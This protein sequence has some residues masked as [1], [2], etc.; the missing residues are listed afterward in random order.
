ME[1]VNSYLSELRQH[2]PSDQCED[3]VSELR[4]NLVEEMQELADSRGG[5]P[6]IKDERAVL[7]NLGHPLKVAAAYKTKRYLIGPNLYPAFLHTLRNTLLIGFLVVFLLRIAG[8]LEA[9][10][11]SLVDGLLFGFV[12]IGLW[13]AGVVGLIFV[14]L[15]ASG[16][17]LGWYH[18]WSPDDLQA[19]ASSVSYTDTVSNLIFE[20][21]FLLWWNSVF[22]LD[23]GLDEQLFNA[24]ELAPIWDGLFWPINLLFAAFILLH[25]WALVRGVWDRWSAVAELALCA[26]LL[27]LIGLLLGAQSLVIVDQVQVAST[28]HMSVAWLNQTFYIVLVVVAGLTVWDGVLAYRRAR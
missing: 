13:I 21:L 8:G 10:F 22:S 16:D 19:N 25:V 17:K 26:G 6:D 18:D 24:I 11:W 2:L 23:W 9:E 28:G 7:A 4:D 20:V 3:I 1:L 14:G 15:E 12:E 5:A 27:L